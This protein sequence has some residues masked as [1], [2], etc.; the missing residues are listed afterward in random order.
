MEDWDEKKL[1]GVLVYWAIWALEGR[2]EKELQ[3]ETELS[4]FHGY[5]SFEWLEG[6]VGHS[7][8]TLWVQC[9][10]QGHGETM[11][12]VDT[13]LISFLRALESK[14]IHLKKITVVLMEF[15]HFKPVIKKK[16]QVALLALFM[17]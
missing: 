1:G 13:E 15:L 10:Y 8:A 16:K 17:C 12:I 5:I 2:G 4:I 11:D 6:K 14:I 7:V 3:G 9:F